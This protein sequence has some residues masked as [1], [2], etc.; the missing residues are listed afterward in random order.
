MIERVSVVGLGKLGLGLALSLANAGFRT[1]GV[2]VSEANVRLLG[3]R[4][5][6]IVEPQYQDLLEQVGDNFEATLDHERA[7]RETDVTFILVATPS[8]ASGRLSSRDV[9]SAAQ[10]LGRALRLSGKPDHLFVIS[11]T[12]V[13]GTVESRI[14]PLLECA[15]G[16]R[17]NDGFSVCYD[18]D[19]VAL[20]S[21][22]HDF[23]HPELVVIGESR[24]EAGERVAAIHHRMCQTAP[25]IARM[26]IVSAE[27]SKVALNAYITLKITFA[28]TLA[29][30]CEV[31]PGADVDAVT[32]AIGVDRRIS[33][34]Y[35]KGGLAFG[36]TCF[37]RDTYGFRSICREHGQDASLVETVA[38][39]NDRQN[40]R[41]ADTVLTHARSNAPVAVLGLAFKSSTPVIEASPAIAVVDALLAA[42][43]DVRVYDTL[44]LDAVN[45][46]YG[47]KLYYASS[48]ADALKGAGLA[49]L[50]LG[51][52]AL[53]KAIEHWTPGDGVTVIDCWRALKGVILNPRVTYIPIGRY[54]EKRAQPFDTQTAKVA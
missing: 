11:S 7:I 13:P 40:E 46:R 31:I 38:T 51:E 35:F 44:A 15:S 10:S 19:F 23:T 12:L 52:P 2:D 20:G 50:T 4:R 41:L 8:D 26:P 1:L 29:N 18:P 34:Y 25:T 27:I 42:G 54:T 28:N 5:T 49:V 37:P 17:L 39:L 14:V 43:H 16:R 48:A 6:P 53:M 3:R 24:P 30:L 32:R 47:D 45:D 9:E 21:V 36:G 22:V 33:P